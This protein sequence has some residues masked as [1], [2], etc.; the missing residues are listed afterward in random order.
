[1]EVSAEAAYDIGLTASFTVGTTQNAT[2]LEA[3]KA[4]STSASLKNNTTTAQ[5]VLVILALYSDKGTMVASSTKAVN[6]AASTTSSV[7]FTNAFTVPTSASSYTVKLF[8]WDGTSIA[9]TRQIPKSN[10]VTLH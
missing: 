6:L 9:D 8:V 2:A 5:P 10:V 7:T 3:G 4:V 1:M